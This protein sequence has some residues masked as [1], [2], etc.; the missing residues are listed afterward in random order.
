MIVSRSDIQK[1]LRH[2]SRRFCGSPALVY[3]SKTVL[4]GFC[5]LGTLFKDAASSRLSKVYCLG[6]TPSRLI[7]WSGATLLGARI[8]TRTQSLR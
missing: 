6:P 3:G 2:V 4:S 8:G 7:G 5:L 1:Q